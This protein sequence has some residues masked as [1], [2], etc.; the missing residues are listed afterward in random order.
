MIL[1]GGNISGI[2]GV[3]DR[4]PAQLLQGVE[5]DMRYYRDN[6]SVAEGIEAIEDC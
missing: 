6:T 5:P 3:G 1:R 4:V 2:E